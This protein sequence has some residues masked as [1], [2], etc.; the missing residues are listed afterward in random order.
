[1]AVE[2]VAASERVGSGEDRDGGTGAWGRRLSAPSP[3]KRVKREMRPAVGS[4]V[5]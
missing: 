1:V 4:S 5:G 2:A 3:A